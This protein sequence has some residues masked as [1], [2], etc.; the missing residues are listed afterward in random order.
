MGLLQLI[1][2]ML[3]LTLSAGVSWVIYV[4]L[5]K[6]RAEAA[7]G[8]RLSEHGLLPRQIYA[9][10]VIQLE[11]KI[12]A[13]KGGKHGKKD[14]PEDHL[15]N[16]PLTAL[17]LFAN[18]ISLSDLRGIALDEFMRAYVKAMTVPTLRQIEL[19]VAS[20]ELPDTDFKKVRRLMTSRQREA[21]DEIRLNWRG[22]LSD[23]LN[24]KAQ[25]ALELEETRRQ[26]ALW[27]KERKTIDSGADLTDW[28]RGQ[29]PDMWHEVCL[30]IRWTQSGAAE[31]VPFVEWL[32]AQPELDTG[33]AL[34]LLANAV[35]DGIDHEAYEQHDCARNQDW[36]KVVHDG[37]VNDRYAPMQ[38]VIPPWTKAEVRALF[39]HR[40][41]GA[42]TV[43]LMQ[44]DP[45]WAKPH[46]PAFSFI[47][48]GP[49][50]SFAAWQLR[51]S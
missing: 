41:G 35:C 28:L 22:R 4:S 19:F 46:N 8:R 2:Y 44:I 48:N 33:S 15:Q 18:H 38:F 36:M 26:T 29:G 31:L 1:A 47:A 37:L 49:V 7:I 13:F 30:N 6:M 27:A 39:V 43:P 21:A 17:F 11:K 9:E 42:W 23:Q 3:G 40:T 24:A 50:E 51:S 14:A 32:V 12:P 25:V 34:V 45:E 5:R 20:A 16:N 10:S